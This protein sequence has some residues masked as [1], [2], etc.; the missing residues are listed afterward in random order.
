MNL[1]NPQKAML[2]DK[3]KCYSLNLEHSLGKH[4]AF[5]F[6]KRLGITLTNKEILE[7]ALIEAIKNQEAIIYKEA[8]FGVHYD[9]KFYLKTDEGESW[10][11]SSWIIR[12][13]E[14]FP[15]LTNVYPINK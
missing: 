12:H 4:K 7:T 9:V 2:G 8:A 15:R 6:Q 3:L 10:I 1:P 14:N 11:L 5:L 13:E